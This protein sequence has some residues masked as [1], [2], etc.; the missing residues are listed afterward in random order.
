MRFRIGRGRV[1][2]GPSSIC[3]LLLLLLLLLL[4]LLLSVVHVALVIAVDQGTKQSVYHLHTWET[5]SLASDARSTSLEHVRLD[6]VGSWP[7]LRLALYSLL[8]AY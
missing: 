1:I 8:F 3:G 4:F 6:S 7:D 5:F 2:N